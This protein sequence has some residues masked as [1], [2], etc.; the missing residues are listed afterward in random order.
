MPVP[1]PGQDSASSIAL[2]TLP[3]CHCP[4]QESVRA[5]MASGDPGVVSG[6]AGVS[7]LQKA[8]YSATPSHFSF[9]FHSMNDLIFF[10]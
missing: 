5:G 8:S 3:V 6:S 10:P 2:A 4:V 7:S 1:R 9:H